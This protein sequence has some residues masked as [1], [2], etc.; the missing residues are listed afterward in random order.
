MKN[1]L[2]KILATLGLIVAIALILRGVFDVGK[3][4][5]KSFS[6]KLPILKCTF[7]DT[8]G[9]KTDHIYDLE[10]IRLNNPLNARKDFPK[11]ADFLERLELEEKI[12]K[13]IDGEF[14]T[15]NKKEDKYKI[16]YKNNIG[17]VTKGHR[18]II[19]RETGESNITFHDDYPRGSTSLKDYIGAFDQAVTFYGIC[20]KYEKQ[21]L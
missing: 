16:Y 18:V 5:I 14:Y 8:D 7:Q 21:N 11:D 9:S 4:G 20:V 6:S 19:N 1:N 17:N 13:K 15:F 12:L 3:I 10:K 2:V